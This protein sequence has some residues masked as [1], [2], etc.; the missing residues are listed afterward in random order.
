MDASKDI[1]FEDDAIYKGKGCKVEATLENTCVNASCLCVY[2]RR[3]AIH[4]RAKFFD[5][6]IHLLSI[7]VTVIFVWHSTRTKMI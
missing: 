5:K 3:C 6:C 4:V 1:F 2:V 7:E